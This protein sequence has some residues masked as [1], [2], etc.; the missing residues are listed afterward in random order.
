MRND[1]GY[2]VLTPMKTCPCLE[3][4]KTLFTTG[5]WEGGCCECGKKIPLNH[6]LIAGAIGLVFTV[7]VGALVSRSR[8]G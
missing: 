1:P 8:R 2:V 7:L 6:L 5:K 3:S 4:V